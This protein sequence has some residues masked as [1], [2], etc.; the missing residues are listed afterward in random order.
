MTDGGTAGLSQ[1]DKALTQAADYVTT[2]QG[3]V[4][5]RCQQLGDQMAG[6]SGQWGGQG[7][8]AFQKLVVSWQ[9]K[10]KTILDAL[11]DL[12]RALQETERDNMATDQSQ[13]DAVSRLQS[14]LS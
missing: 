9:E 13:A 8:M 12:S 5:K 4:T 6:L 7:A 1:A 3:D 14:R 2:A 11:G 10:Q